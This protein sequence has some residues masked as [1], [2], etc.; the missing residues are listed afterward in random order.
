MG[1]LFPTYAIG[2]NLGELL[3]IQGL[4]GLSRMFTRE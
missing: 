4:E 2:V 1:G 3:N